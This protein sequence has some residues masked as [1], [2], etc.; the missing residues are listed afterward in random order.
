MP[1]D[2]NC[3]Y[4]LYWILVK[5]RKKFRKQLSDSGIETGTHYCQKLFNT[6]EE[7]MEVMRDRMFE[8]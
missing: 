8:K 5:N 6:E 2:V 3:S 4:H 7:V 1:Y